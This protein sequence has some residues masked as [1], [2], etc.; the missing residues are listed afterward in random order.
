MKILVATKATQNFRS[1]DFSWANNDEIVHFGSECDGGSIDG[2]CG[3]RRSMTGIDS[4]K[5]TTTMRVIDSDIS[6]AQLAYRISNSMISA[7][8]YEK[9]EASDAFN[10]AKKEAAELVRIASCFPVDSIIEKRGNKFAQRKY[11]EQITT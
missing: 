3:C 1:N 5:G 4:R 9:S 7:G 10:D 6:M 11:A 2:K 8:Y